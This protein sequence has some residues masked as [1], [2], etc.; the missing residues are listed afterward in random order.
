MLIRIPHELKDKVK[1]MADAENRSINQQIEFLLRR[2]VD[3]EGRAR[4]E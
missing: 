1:R 4:N 3:V 2:A